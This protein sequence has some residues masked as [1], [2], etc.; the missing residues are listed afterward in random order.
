MCWGPNTMKTMICCHQAIPCP[1][2]GLFF[3]RQVERESEEEERWIHRLIMP[4]G[5]DL[6]PVTLFKHS[7]PPWICWPQVTCVWCSYNPSRILTPIQLFSWLSQ[8][9][10]CKHFP[11][12]ASPPPA[13]MCRLRTATGSSQFLCQEAESLS[14]LP[15]PELALCPALSD[16]CGFQI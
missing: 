9:T 14:L 3:E 4:H 12:C 16:G 11:K 13:H 10:R 5:C 15:K 6:V 8:S 2:K 1:E 7:L